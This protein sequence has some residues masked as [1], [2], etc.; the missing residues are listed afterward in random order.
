MKSPTNLTTEKLTALEHYRI[1]LKFNKYYCD[2]KPSVTIN[3]YPEEYLELMTEV[4]KTWDDMTGI[5]VLPRSEHTYK[6]APFEAITEEEYYKL[7][8][9]YK[10]LDNLDFQDLRFYE[11]ENAR[12]ASKKVQVELSCTAGSCEI[13][14]L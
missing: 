11:K 10:H 2:H 7:V 9:D 14:N 4:Y 13:T 5:S 8:Q 1:W 12:D 6:Q 3:Y